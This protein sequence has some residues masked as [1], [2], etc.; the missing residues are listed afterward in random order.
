VAEELGNFQY[1]LREVSLTDKPEWFTST[2]HRALGADPASSGKVP[3]LVEP[4][5]GLALA[6]SAVVAAYLADKHG[7]ERG[8]FQADPLERARIAL[9]T[10]QVVGKVRRT[11]SIRALT[12]GC[13][14]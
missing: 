9:F 8:A 6:E 7:P 5:A 2:Y 10:D 4:D 1:E 14:A 3:V 11:P 12:A 13:P